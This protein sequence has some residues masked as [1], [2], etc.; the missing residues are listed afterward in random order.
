MCT[1]TIEVLRKR[2]RAWQDASSWQSRCISD[3]CNL[4][5]EPAKA[6]SS[7]G[8]KTLLGLL[9]VFHCCFFCWSCKC[10]IVLDFVSQLAHWKYSGLIN[11][12]ACAVLVYTFFCLPH[13]ARGA[14]KRSRRILPLSL[15]LSWG[16]GRNPQ[17]KNPPK[18]FFPILLEPWASFCS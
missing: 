13:F 9:K 7:M 5:W 1:Q 12:R 6:R 16:W 17:E 2:V 4:F 15:V 18:C 11:S 10:K 14:I 3:A 8:E